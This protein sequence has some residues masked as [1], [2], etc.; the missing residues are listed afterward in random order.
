MKRAH[1]LTA[2]Y[3]VALHQRDDR[4]FVATSL[5]LPALAVSTPCP[6][7]AVRTLRDR[8]AASLAD[9]LASG[10]APAPL[11]DSEGRLGSWAVDL[12]ILD[13]RRATDAEVEKPSP[14]ILRAIARS[15]AER[16]RIILE[17]H[18]DGGFIAGCAEVA[19]VVAHGA[20]VTR[21]IDRLRDLLTDFAYRTLDAN[22][23][24]P[25][26]LQ[27]VEARAVARRAA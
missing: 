5:E 25:E 15:T 20:T 6:D 12:E 13:A 21:A 7:Q 1:I 16:Y 23:M 3:R 24:P 27:D 14:D 19:G 4:S 11:R 22:D 8:I 2:Q 17:S 18:E 26:P 9:L 10:D